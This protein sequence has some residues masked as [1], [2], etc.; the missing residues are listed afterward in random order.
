M[1]KIKSWRSHRSLAGSTHGDTTRAYHN[2]RDR[3]TTAMNS[4]LKRVSN[5]KT[6]NTYVASDKVERVSSFR[7]AVYLKM[8]QYS[9]ERCLAPM[10]ESVPCEIGAHNNGRL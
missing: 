9:M 7:Y 5:R 8:M 6:N 4:T 1:R 10:K 2:H 3:F